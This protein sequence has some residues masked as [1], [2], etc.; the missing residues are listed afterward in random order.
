VAAQD[1]AVA[2]S[3][4][5]VIKSLVD[6]FNAGDVAA[7]TSAYAE[8]GDIGAPIGMIWKGR[9]GIEEAWTATLGAYK[10]STMEISRTG[11]HVVSPEVVVVD[12]SWEFRGGTIAEGH[13]T[14]GF[15]TLVV[16]KQGDAWRVVS[17]RS[18]VPPPN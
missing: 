16:A 1:P 18:K 13:P 15:I 3:M 10:G 5:G 2:Q 9:A 6:G 4:D 11:L 14:T 12:G 7:L 17:S 8:D